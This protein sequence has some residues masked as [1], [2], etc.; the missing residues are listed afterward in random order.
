MVYYKSIQEYGDYLYNSMIQSGY[1]ASICN[2]HKSGT[3]D[4]LDHHKPDGFSLVFSNSNLEA[5]SQE[6]LNNNITISKT[7]SPNAPVHIDIVPGATWHETIT[8]FQQNV[9]QNEVVVTNNTAFNVTAGAEYKGCSLGLDYTTS[10][11]TTETDINNSVTE[12]TINYDLTFTGIDKPYSVDFWTNKYTCSMK[13]RMNI[14][15]QFSTINFRAVCDYHSHT[16][17]NH[18]NNE[19]YNKTYDIASIGL[20]PTVTVEQD[21]VFNIDYDNPWPSYSITY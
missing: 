15:Y 7:D 20:D 17:G 8:K 13:V 12:S 6:F 5:K 21:V 2:S 16:W 9:H 4:R 18:F 14:T 10:T 3:K 11:S 1:D 19:H